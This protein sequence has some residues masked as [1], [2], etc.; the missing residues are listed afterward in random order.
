MLFFKNFMKHFNSFIKQLFAFLFRHIVRFLTV[1]KLTMQ[2][3]YRLSLL[4]LPLP[5]ASCRLVI[6]IAGQPIL[7]G[8]SSFAP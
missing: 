6:S 1:S 5:C 3:Y 7:R 8:F 4:S 2:G